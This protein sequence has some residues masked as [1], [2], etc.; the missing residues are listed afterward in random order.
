M[1]VLRRRSIRDRWRFFCSSCVSLPRPICT[2]RMHKARP[3]RS[4]SWATAWPRATGS[5]PQQ[6]FP[7]APARPP[8][9]RR[10]ATSPSSITASRAT[11]RRAALERIDWMLAD[12]PDIVLVE[13]GANDALR[14]TDPAVTEHNLDAIITKLEGGRRHGV[15]GRHAGAAQLRPGIRRPVRRALQAARRKA[16]GAALSL[17]PRRRG[18]GS[19]AQPGRRHPSQSRRASTVMVERMLPFVTKNLDDYAA[20]VR[21]P[22]RP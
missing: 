17:L 16:P 9:R 14:G 22:A 4:P 10:R 3:S 21:R 15:A 20:S 8:S 5:S 11:P 6:A 19:G 7:V 12:K 13:L 2:E 18:A 1:V